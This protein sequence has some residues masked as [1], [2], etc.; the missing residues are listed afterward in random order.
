M[1]GLRHVARRHLQMEKNGELGGLASTVGV[2]IPEYTT[3]IRASRSME[4]SNACRTS[5]F[6]PSVVS[7][8][9]PLL[10]LIEMP[11]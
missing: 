8:A 5:A 9:E 1:L 4:N 6:F 11:V 2:Y 10:V 3:W 7:C